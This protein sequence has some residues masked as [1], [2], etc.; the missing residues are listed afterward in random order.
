MSL[1]DPFGTTQSNTLTKGGLKAGTITSSSG[2]SVG[3]M[4]NPFEYTIAKSTTWAT[5]VVTGRNLPLTSFTSGAP[6]TLSVTLYFDTLDTRTATNSTYTNVRDHTI[7]LLNMMMIDEANQNEKTKKSEPPTVTFKWG[8]VE[9]KGVITS[10]SEKLT[11]FSEG[12]VPLRAE[13]TLKLQEIFDKEWDSSQVPDQPKWAARSAPKS[14]QFSAGTRLDLIGA[15]KGTITK[16]VETGKDAANT[17]RNIAEGNNIDDPLNIPS[18][19]NLL[20][21]QGKDTFT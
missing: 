14:V 15:F 13:V 19:A 2:G 4:F 16:A 10:M 21:T 12:G 17:M 3:F 20:L 8:E 6:M 7:Q 18:G 9:F 11:L 5:K 1:S